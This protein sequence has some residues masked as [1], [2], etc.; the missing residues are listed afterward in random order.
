MSERIKILTG[1]F[2]FLILFGGCRSALVPAG[3]KLSPREVSN[4]FTGSWIDIS[5]GTGDTAAL[6]LNLSGELIAL[7]EDTAYVLTE[8][9]FVPLTVKNI[10]SAKLHVFNPQAAIWPV[11]G[12]LSFIPN[13]VG[14]IANSTG[15]GFVLL[16][17]PVAGFGILF[18]LAETRSNAT[19][20]YPDKSSFDEFVKFA[21]YPQGLPAGLET[22]KL[23]LI[24]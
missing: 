9:A 1:I 3:Y 17:A 7:N 6:K 5:Y 4:S 23:H 15:G 22:G 13:I 19:L 24:K 2:G 11:S 20:K 18:G 16:G 8:T 21:R 10:I 14:E 12:L